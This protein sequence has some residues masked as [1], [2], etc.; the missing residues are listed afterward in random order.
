M[1]NTEKVAFA[2]IDESGEKGLVR[3]LA[4]ADDGKFGLM[5]A[6]LFPSEIHDK[7]LQ[8]FTPGFEAF[9]NASP[10]KAKLHFTDAYIPGNESWAKVAE[11]VRDEFIG[12][13]LQLK[14]MI[15]YGARRLAL[16]RIAHEQGL[17]MKSKVRTSSRSNVRIPGADRDSDDRIE[18]ELI[19]SL[20]LRLDAFG[21]LV[22][23][24]GEPILIDLLF[25]KT[26]ES[27]AKRYKNIVESTRHIS[28][29]TS[30]VSGWDTIEK[31]KLSRNI[32]FSVDSPSIRVDTKYLRDIKIVGKNHPLVLAADLVA[33]H[34]NHHL[35]QL[36]QN[37][38]LNAPSSIEDWVLAERVWGVM[39]NASEDVF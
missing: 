7:A 20:S 3:N 16:S 18:D 38:P 22:E 2:Y 36:N 11:N 32:S 27:V 9:Q 24:N 37:A 33:N 23:D 13:I 28:A 8:L 34:L 26:D 6:L 29:S 4:Q 15:L 10:K 25:D 5:T 31:R 35:G 17:E 39:V 19:L 1:S 30:T 21:E 12:L 14:P